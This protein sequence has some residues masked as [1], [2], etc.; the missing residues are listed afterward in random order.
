ME[1]IDKTKEEQWRL[2]DVVK[3]DEYIAMIV[4]N[5]DEKYCLMDISTDTSSGY[6]TCRMALWGYPHETL[7]ELQ[8][9]NYVDWHKVNTK[10]VIE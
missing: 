7:K 8:S 9:A 4:Q 2:G 5:N 10:L 6:S 3:K 1:I